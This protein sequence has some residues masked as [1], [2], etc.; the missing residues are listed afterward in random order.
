MIALTFLPTIP[1]KNLLIRCN[2]FLQKQKVLILSGIIR[3]DNCTMEDVIQSTE[4][5][6]CSRDDDSLYVATKCWERVMDAAVKTG[7]REGAQDGADSVL[8]E[9]FDIGYRDGFETAFTLG[10]YKGLAAVSTSAPEHPADVAAVLDKTR[11]GACR[12]CDVES[13]RKA[14]SPHED[15]PFDEVLNEQRAHSAEV[16]GRLRE[17]FEPILKRSGVN[18]I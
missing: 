18:S 7:Y 17:Y 11:R 4:H 5:D 3:R 12:I 15:A 14:P 2:F 10:R 9:G 16:I 13:R 1:I 6:S 8:Q